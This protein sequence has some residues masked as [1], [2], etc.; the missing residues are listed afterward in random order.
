MS[1]DEIE[2]L[3]KKAMQQNFDFALLQEQQKIKE[4]CLSIALE[5]FVA[6]MNAPL[7]ALIE[8]IKLS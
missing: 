6:Q 7:Y 1:L 4:N 8:E 5:L 3:R 2:Q